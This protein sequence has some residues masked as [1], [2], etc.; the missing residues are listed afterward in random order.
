MEHKTFDVKVEDGA[1]VLGLDPNKDGED[2]L[3][4]KVYLSEAVQEAMNRSAPV[5]GVKVVSLSFENSRLK[6][7]LDTDKDGEAVLDLELDLIEGFE[8]VQSALSKKD[9]APE[10]AE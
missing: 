7:K 8:E 2:V 5:E 10:Q 4:A 3:K 6:L 1:L 9:E